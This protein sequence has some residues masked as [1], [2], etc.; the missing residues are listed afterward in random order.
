ME[1]SHKILCPRCGV[2][3]NHHAD[4]LVE[5]APLEGSVDSYAEKLLELHACPLC[6]ET[7]SRTRNQL[8]L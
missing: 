1:N 2:E 3:M 8:A 5:A 7:V 6:G 4:K